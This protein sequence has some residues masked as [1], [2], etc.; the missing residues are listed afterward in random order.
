MDTK[1]FKLY[2]AKKVVM[3]GKIDEMGVVQFMAK[4]DL[5]QE[6]LTNIKVQKGGADELVE[7]DE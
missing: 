1:K 7:D 5:Y 2:K 4:K 6:A 3:Q